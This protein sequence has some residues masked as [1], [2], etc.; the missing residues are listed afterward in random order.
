MNYSGALLDITLVA[1]SLVAQNTYTS[2]LWIPNLQDHLETQLSIEP[3]KVAVE[4]IKD[5]RIFMVVIAPINSE[6][7]SLISQTMLT[8]QLPRLQLCSASV[9]TVSVAS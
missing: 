7:L 6:T 4:P 1:V 8:T 2:D 9:D 5:I 3:I